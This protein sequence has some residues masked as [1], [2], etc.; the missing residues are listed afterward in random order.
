L[1]DSRIARLV[2]M[3]TM[4]CGCSLALLVAVICA[5]W[6]Y[7]DDMQRMEATLSSVGTFLSS[8]LAGSLVHDSKECAAI[9]Q[10]MANLNH[11]SS[12]E[13]LGIDGRFAVS[14]GSLQRTG[15]IVRRFPFRASAGGSVFSAVL[16]VAG[17]PELLLRRA[18]IKGLYLFCVMIL[19]TGLLSGVLWALFRDRFIKPL[20]SLIRHTDD[21]R[22]DG[23][24]SPAGL[25]LRERETT[26]PD[27]IDQL[28]SAVSALRQRFIQNLNDRK[29][30][31]GLRNQE[32]V[33]L[34]TLINSI[35]D[36]IF[37]KDT[38]S[39]YLGC[40]T[41]FEEFSGWKMHKLVGLTDFDLFPAAQAAFFR[42]QD[43]KMFAV[44]GP[45]S[46]EE[47]I[48]YPD[49]RTALL[50]TLKTVCRDENGRLLG[51]IGI[52]RDITQ[53]KVVEN[54]LKAAQHRFEEAFNASPVMIMILDC[55]AGRFIDVNLPCLQKT[56]YLKQEILSKTLTDLR[57]WGGDEDHGN[58]MAEV[59]RDGRVEGL[60][61]R[62]RTK[63][64]REVSCLLSGRKVT[65]S[66]IDCL[67][68]F[69]EDLSRREMAERALQ[70]SESRFRDFANSAAD[71]FWEMDKDLRFTYLTGKVEEIMGKKSEDIVGSTWG[72]V[73]SG[74]GR[75]ESAGW[76]INA[77]RILRHEAF[78]G[79]E[80]DWLRSEGKPRRIALDGRPV[81]DM[82]GRFSGYRGT[83]RDI[84]HRKEA[85]EALQRAMKMDA[86]GHVMGGIAHDFNNILGIIIGNL[87]Y[88]KRF[89]EVD[90]TSLKRLEAVSKASERGN[91]LTRQLLDFSRHQAR[92]CQPANIN[93]ILQGM[94]SLIARSVTPEVEVLTDL[95]ADLWTTDIDRGDFEDVVLNL[96]INAR[97]AMAKGGRLHISTSNAT[98]DEYYTMM[99]PGMAPGNYILLAVNDTG[100]GMP[101]KVLEHIFEPFYTT[102][103]HGK[104]TGLGLSMVYAFTQR[105]KGGIKVYSEPGTG[106]SIHMYL[107]KSKQELPQSPGSPAAMPGLPG[108]NET[109]LIVDDE[110]DLLA[111]TADML[112][113]L[114]YTTLTAKNG[115]EAMA[116]LLEKG[117]AIDLLY[118]DVVMPGGMNGFELAEQAL[119]LRPDLKVLFTS[120]YF[121]KAIPKAGQFAFS[122]RILFKPYY[123]LDLAVRIHEV[124]HG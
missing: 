18:I 75:D 25:P 107:P 77:N 82:D 116:V 63:S 99:N 86:V 9:L 119:L 15:M 117:A 12:L 92:E 32:R 2:L 30:A 74:S 94:D 81:T 54:E 41:A 38:D 103:P 55:E 123:E 97:D 34:T 46:N 71:W 58:I 72:Q 98:L 102:K 70:I 48:R 10:N 87:D 79:F 49:G 95:A 109:I 5:V 57:F 40:N 3:Y 42:D 47:W 89:G 80:I 52:S 85:E 43:K 104:G 39:V 28:A 13:V 114:G 44:G 53:R 113:V 84:T 83:G 110:V 26:A 106:T 17:D 61:V 50:D 112:K 35:P 11:L 37:Y 14:V 27:E 108:G 68:F 21:S 6:G 88:I 1:K 96:V 78:A 120:G 111:L 51:M 73:F 124:L 65:F 122:P 36:L 62:I 121:E 31:E 20:Q 19:F 118:T 60:P 22:L 16:T 64:G 8:E 93:T 33:L 76:K 115:N 101:P 45:R 90:G 67:L 7:K 23:F 29:E 105:S 59:A 66:M 24:D 56:G 69:L 91:T 4:S 100:D